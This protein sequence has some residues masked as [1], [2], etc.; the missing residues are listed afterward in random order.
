MYKNTFIEALEQQDYETLRKIPKTDLHNHCTFGGSQD[1]LLLSSL[2]V[3][4]SFNDIEEFTKWC[5]VNIDKY[6]PGIDGKKERIAASFRQATSDTII[7]LAL[8]IG[9]KTILKLGGLSSYIH[10]MTKIQKANYNDGYFMPELGLK[11]DM[12]IKEN[13]ELIQS[14]ISTK[15]FYSIDLS[16]KNNYVNR[17]EDFVDIYRYA[18]KEKLTLKA[19]VGEFTKADDIVRYIETLHLHQ[20][21]HGITAAKSKFVMNYLQRNNIT[22][23]ICPSSN[24][25]FGVCNNTFDE[26]KELLH[27]GVKITINS[28][29]LLVFKSDISSE[30]LKLYQMGSISATELNNIRD[31]SINLAYNQYIRNNK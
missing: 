29:D 16:G 3:P 7:Y 30:F 22:L 15:I 20:I 5:T 23:N 11:M 27:A 1:D 10:T 14:A 18:E 8:I 24:L 26:I 9:Y 2:V 31:Y 13:K 4:K 25:F 19:H 6:Y 12:N 21:N 28:D 17:L